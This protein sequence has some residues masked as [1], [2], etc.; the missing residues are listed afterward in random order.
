MV[1]NVDSIQINFD[2]GSTSLPS[3]FL[4]AADEI[5]KGKEKRQKIAAVSCRLQPVEKRVHRQFWNQ[6]Q[7]KQ[8]Q[9][10]RFAGTMGRT[11]FPF[12]LS[13]LSA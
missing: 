10:Y 6:L 13:L 9:L 3:S 2:G 11:R 12:P 5:G 7:Q 8:R 4:R 1:S